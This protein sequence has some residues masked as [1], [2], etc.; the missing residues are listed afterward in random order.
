MCPS[1]SIVMA[2]PHHA[3]IM[4][5]GPQMWEPAQPY[6]HSGSVTLEHMTVTD[7]VVVVV[8]TVT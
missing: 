2:E 6:H 7:G 3:E 4:L 1:E 8:V 5:I